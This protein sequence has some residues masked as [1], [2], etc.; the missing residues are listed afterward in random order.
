MTPMRR[1]IAELQNLAATRISTPDALT[2]VAASGMF[3]NERGRPS[4]RPL[5]VRPRGGVQAHHKQVA[6]YHPVALCATA[7]TGASQRSARWIEAEAG[8]D[9][10]TNA[11]S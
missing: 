10:A 4:R 9:L 1:L 2:W 3:E 11:A 8:P 6:T 7:A 5:K